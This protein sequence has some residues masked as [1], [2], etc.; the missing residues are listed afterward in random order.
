M[1][2]AHRIAAALGRYV[3][4]MVLLVL[5]LVSFGLV[6]MTLH[7]VARAFTDFFPSLVKHHIDGVL[8][9]LVPTMV[10]LSLA[11]RFCMWLDDRDW[12]IRAS[13]MKKTAALTFALCV[14]VFAV[15]QTR[16]P[17]MA[18]AGVPVPVAAVLQNLPF[19]FR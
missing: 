12:S 5:F 13:T 6:F 1:D 11:L 14:V 8:L 3:R 4:G 10:A 18:F 16:R 15:R 2:S 19:G 7:T 9:F 17:E